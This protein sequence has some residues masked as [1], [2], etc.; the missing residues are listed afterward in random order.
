MDGRCSGIGDKDIAV[1]YPAA[2]QGVECI[3]NRASGRS[4]KVKYFTQVIRPSWSSLAG[5]TNPVVF[6]PV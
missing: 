6:P 5:E 4:T 1:Q 3:S 2:S